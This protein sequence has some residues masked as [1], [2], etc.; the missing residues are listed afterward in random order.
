MS[1]TCELAVDVSL[2]V[3][4]ANTITHAHTHIHTQHRHHHCTGPYLDD[5][6]EREKFSDAYRAMTDAF[7]AFPLC[8]PGTAVWKGRQG[9]LF[10][11]KV[12]TKAAARSKAKMASGAEPECLLDFWSQAVLQVGG[13]VESSGWVEVSI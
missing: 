1:C 13:W 12:L 9:R 6:V 5:P 7:L 4:Q 11:I 2:E 10:I 8:V 3:H